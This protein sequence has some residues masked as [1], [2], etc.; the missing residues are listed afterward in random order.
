[1]VGSLLPNRNKVN[2]IHWSWVMVVLFF[3]TRRQWMFFDLACVKSDR[4]RA[5]VFTEP[6]WFITITFV[7]LGSIANSRTKCWIYWYQLW[8]TIPIKVK[9][10][11]YFPLTIPKFCIIYVCNNLYLDNIFE[12][13][14]HCIFTYSGSL[15]SCN[16]DCPILHFRK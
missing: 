12:A 4:W 13:Y 9:E 15:N 11:L 2:E 3:K 7:C 1:M 14:L 8:T 10:A 16:S 5:K 6:C